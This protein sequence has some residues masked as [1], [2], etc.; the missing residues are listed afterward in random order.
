MVVVGLETGIARLTVGQPEPPR[1]RGRP[2]SHRTETR[3]HPA[4]AG[5]AHYPGG[6]LS[7][8]SLFNIN[9][10][11]ES[12]RTVQMPPRPRRVSAKTAASPSS[13]VDHGN[14]ERKS[15]KVYLGPDLP[16]EVWEQVFD[17][18]AWDGW[19]G[20]LR[21]C[22]LSCRLWAPRCG[23]HLAGEVVVRNRR[24]GHRVAKAMAAPYRASLA[25]A[26]T[27]TLPVGFIAG[28]PSLSVAA[29]K[30]GSQLRGR[31]FW[32]ATVLH[33]D[34]FAHL[35]MTFPNV[36]RLTLDFVVFPSAV[37][38]ARLVYSFPHL[39]R[40]ACYSVSFRTR[41]R[42][43]RGRALPP[44][45]FALADLE[46]CASVDVVDFLVDSSAGPGLHRIKC[47]DLSQTDVYR[48]VDCAGASL[49]SLNF[50]CAKWRHHTPKLDLG[51]L[52]GL[53]SLAL[54]LDV[55]ER[56][57]GLDGAAFWA[58]LGV[59]LPASAQPQLQTLTVSVNTGVMYDENGV[60]GV[61]RVLDTQSPADDAC[62]HIDDLLTAPAYCRLQS[63][64]FR[65]L[66]HNSVSN[67][68]WHAPHSRTQ[69]L[70]HQHLS[71]LFP[72]I[73]AHQLLRSSVEMRDLRM[74]LPELGFWR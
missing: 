20:T 30:I 18:L 71:C 61:L 23:W 53:E 33:V 47:E 35:R 52:L 41:G 14:S 48:L 3:T 11:P 57:P 10:R 21:N 39:A 12:S 37:V 55:P 49:R 72:K 59:V 66:Y 42:S 60:Q 38:F 15:E 4:S 45:G 27:L 7:P 24:H 8:F 9:S 6:F 62:A 32:E 46:L 50:T 26:I 74:Y 54:T 58:Q 2:N 40:L 13:R 25:R 44:K 43:V 22:A 34:V 5:G 56:H 69:Q 1:T 19:L 17:L 51:G 31:A 36:T 64:S 29:L 70:W 16:L 73:S 67:Y 28:R 65:L 68:H 63:V